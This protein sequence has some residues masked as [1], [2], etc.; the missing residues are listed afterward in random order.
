MF[1]SEYWTLYSRL[2]IEDIIFTFINIQHPNYG[3]ENY[4][5][6]E[7]IGREM[8]RAAYYAEVKVSASGNAMLIRLLG[9]MF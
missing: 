9:R 6:P 8:D 4:F 1:D 5:V 3:I 7:G 2:L